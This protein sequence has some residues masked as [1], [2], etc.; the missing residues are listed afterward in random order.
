MFSELEKKIGVWFKKLEVFQVMWW[1]VKLLGMVAGA[2]FT[3]NASAGEIVWLRAVNVALI[4][5]AW[6]SFWWLV[7]HTSPSEVVTRF[8]YGIGLVVMSGVV[9]GIAAGWIDNVDV[10][11]RISVML[12]IAR[13]LYAVGGDY[14]SYMNRPQVQ[15]RNH[16]RWEERTKR[17][18]SRAATRAEIYADARMNTLRARAARRAL[19]PWPVG[20]VARDLQKDVEQDVRE[21]LGLG[22]GDVINP[23]Q[24]KVGQNGQKRQNERVLFLED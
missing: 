17:Q 5:G 11:A 21:K 1:A 23:F 14:V 7:D 22:G 4:D 10:S 20:A 15:E 6:W 24:L 13:S 2:Y 8:M 16:R 18:A 12:L 9:L 19:A 3:W